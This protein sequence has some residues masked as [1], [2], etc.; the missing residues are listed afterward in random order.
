MCWWKIF[1]LRILRQAPSFAK[2]LK[3]KRKRHGLINIEQLAT[4]V[5]LKWERCWVSPPKWVHYSTI[6]LKREGKIPELK[7]R[8]EASCCSSQQA[9]LGSWWLQDSRCCSCCL[10]LPSHG[11]TLIISCFFPDLTQSYS[12][13]LIYEKEWPR[14][15]HSSNTAHATEYFTI[16]KPRNVFELCK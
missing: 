11:Q 5:W 7:P 1:K 15:P 6:Y 9:V 12:L 2:Y 3:G 16:S 8:L 4:R 14:L 10:K 13:L